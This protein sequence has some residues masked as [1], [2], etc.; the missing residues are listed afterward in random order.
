MLILWQ[1][2]ATKVGVLP[3]FGEAAVNVLGRRYKLLLRRQHK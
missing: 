3:D 1:Q 2:F